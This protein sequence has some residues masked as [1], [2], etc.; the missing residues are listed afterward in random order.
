[1]NEP[2]QSKITHLITY[3]KSHNLVDDDVSLGIGMKDIYPLPWL[4]RRYIVCDT[5]RKL[6]YS[7]RR[8][9]DKCLHRSSKSHDL[10]T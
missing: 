5:I 8:L 7:N 9:L 10:K 3:C 2:Y 6:E 1:M 4:L